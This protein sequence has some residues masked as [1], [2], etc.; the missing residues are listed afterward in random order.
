LP[1][2]RQSRQQNGELHFE[3]INAVHVPIAWA[4]LLLMPALAAYGWRRKK[5]ADLGLLA[6]TVLLAVVAN[7][8]ICGPLSNPHDRYG[9]RL[10]WLAPLVALLAVAR[11]QNRKRPPGAPGG[12]RIRAREGNRASRTGGR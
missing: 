5:F 8:F 1:A 7:A 6:A 2:L 3:A 12:R 10:A 11:A 9:A 4:A